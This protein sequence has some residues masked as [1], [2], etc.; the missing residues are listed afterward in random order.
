MMGVDNKEWDDKHGARSVSEIISLSYYVMG[1]GKPW[2]LMLT[3]L[4]LEKKLE[5][6]NPLLH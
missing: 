6:M 2:C 5:G 3:M 4:G 1:W